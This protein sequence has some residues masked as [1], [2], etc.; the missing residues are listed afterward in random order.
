MLLSLPEGHVHALAEL[1][2]EAT[3]S[4]YQSASG[5]LADIGRGFGGPTLPVL[6]ATR[7]MT[8]LMSRFVSSLG[9]EGVRL[10]GFVETV[11]AMSASSSELGVTQ[12]S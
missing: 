5:F 2:G 8:A 9:L 6:Y 10:R 1:L 11:I 7:V 12:G 4:W 3:F